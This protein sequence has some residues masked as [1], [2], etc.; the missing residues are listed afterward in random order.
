MLTN[1]FAVKQQR[2]TSPKAIKSNT[3]P[4][5]TSS[6]VKSAVNTEKTTSGRLPLPINFIGFHDP[7]FYDQNL[8][9]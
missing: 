7:D 2:D 9:T 8:V 5:Y 4:C 3:T 6:N 1:N